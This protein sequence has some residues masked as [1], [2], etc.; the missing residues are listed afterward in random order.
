[1]KNVNQKANVQQVQVSKVMAE[2][3]TNKAQVI[4]G[5]LKDDIAIHTFDNGDQLV[6]S[7]VDG[8]YYGIGD[9]KHIEVYYA[10]ADFDHE[11]N[12][13]FLVTG[14]EYFSQYDKGAAI[15]SF[16]KRLNSK[17]PSIFTEGTGSSLEE[18]KAH[19]IVIERN[20]DDSINESA[21]AG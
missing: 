4:F 12:E 16:M 15:S 8:R 2:T 6:I 17:N 13:C 11:G 21:F 5:L 18:I 14:G 1:M 3:I 9:L 20:L 10:E 19:D 7:M